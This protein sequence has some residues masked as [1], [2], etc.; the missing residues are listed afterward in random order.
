MR[1]AW[2]ERE[3]LGAGCVLSF[4]AE[5]MRSPNS[6]QWAHPQRAARRVCALAVAL[7]QLAELR[8]ESL[9]K[10]QVGAEAVGARPAACDSPHR[11]CAERDAALAHVSLPSTALNFTLT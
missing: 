11:T 4:D 2:T 5:L 10:L 6:L 3:L 9:A 7:T 1:V 8:T